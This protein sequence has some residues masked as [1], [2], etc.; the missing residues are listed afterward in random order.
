MQV[1]QNQDF[2]FDGFTVDDHGAIRIPILGE[3]N[4]MVTP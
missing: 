3:L 2:Y 4:V 1:N